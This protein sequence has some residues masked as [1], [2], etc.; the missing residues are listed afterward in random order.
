MNKWHNFCKYESHN[1]GNK[2]CVEIFKGYISLFRNLGFVEIGGQSNC[3]PAP[4][5]TSPLLTPLF[6]TISLKN[7]PGKAFLGILLERKC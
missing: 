2:V 7:E 5:I 3:P 1:F 4:L 6:Y